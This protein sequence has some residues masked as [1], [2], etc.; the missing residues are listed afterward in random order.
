MDDLFQYLKRFEKYTKNA[1]LMMAIGLMG[2]LSV[3]IVPLPSF[4]LDLALT[5]SL[6]ISLLVLVVALYINSPLEFSIFPSLLLITTLFRLA[7]NVASTRLI[8][9]EGHTGPGAAG[10]VITAFGQFVVGDNYAIGFIVFI[11]LTIINFVVITKGSGRIAEVAARFTLDALPGKQMSIDADLNAGLINE[12]QARARRR[13]IE[14]EA[15]FYGAMDGAS[16]FVRGDAIAGIII[17]AINIIGGLAIGVIQM[18]IGAADAAEFYTRLT[19]GDGLVSQIPALI[20]STAAGIVVTR[21]HSKGNVGSEMMGQLFLNPRAVGVAAASM[22]VLGLV[23]GLPTL[24]FTI[25]S[26][27]L[28]GIAWM[29][30]KYQ[31]EE[32]REETNRKQE[33]SQRPKKENIENLLPL[34]LVELE[35]GYGLI[36]A[37]ESEQ[38]GDLLERIVSIRKQFALDLGIVVPSVHIRDNLQLKPGEYR[39]LL[40]GNKVT[41]GELK[42]DCFLAMDPGNTSQ[43]IDGIPTKEPAFGL[44]ALWITKMQKEDAEM[45]GYTVVDIPTVI[46]THI[47]EILRQHAAELFGRQEASKLIENFKKTYPKVVEDLI[48]DTLS[49]GQV[50]RV[51]QNLLK[52]QVSIRDLL[53]IF[54]TLADEGARNKDTD[55]LTESV[56][57]S[58]RRAITTK[59]KDDADRIHVINLS[60]NVEEIINQS[61]LQT[62][63]GVQLAL[64][65]SY[66]HGLVNSIAEQIESHPEVAGQ[67]ILLTSP[68]TRRH[69]FKLV[70]RFIPQLVVL[71]HSELSL[72][73]TVK[74]VGTVEDIHAS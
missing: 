63:Q 25:V 35:I 19:I 65:P 39:I 46:A 72:D 22:F 13:E 40:K 8:L 34:D 3:M 62:E 6:T 64:D 59:L 71:S 48:P 30:F 74:T 31:D 38:S 28:G 9:S 29:I 57:K 43:K 70:N 18:G 55:V 15:D 69:I 27:S 53:T 49:L 2:I 68:M 21:N 7:L 16:K 10:E 56:R 17:M 20:I 5:G 45:A 61:L 12:E 73:V 4:M 66:G 42:P 52:E 37:V 14:A 58:L 47:T 26:L 50:V 33:E 51:L 24:P 36:N 32:K 67:P 60:S 23:P 54:E 11:I 41:S 1:D 44:D